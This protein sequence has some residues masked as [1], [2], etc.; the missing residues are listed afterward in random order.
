MIIQGYHL[1][2]IQD[3]FTYPTVGQQKH[4]IIDSYKG[5]FNVT[6]PA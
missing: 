4:N 5:Y 3:N 6:L 1:A 2:N